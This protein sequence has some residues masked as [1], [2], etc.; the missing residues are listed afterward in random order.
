MNS[1][2]RRWLALAL[3][4]ARLAGRPR[5]E[6]EE[7]VRRSYDRIAAGYDA[8]WTHHMRDLS[9][10][11]LDRL[12]EVG[13]AAAVDLCCGTG[14]VTGALAARTGRP[15][16]GVDASPGMLA[17]ARAAHPGCAFVEADAAAWLRA[18]PPASADVIVTA[19][20]LGYARPW[21]LLRAARRVLRPGGRLAV[22]DNGL[23]SL[24]GVVRASVLAF[25]ERPDALAHVL[26]VG[27]LPSSRAL[28]ALL[29]AAGLRP[30]ARWDGARSYRVASGEEAIARLQ[31]TGAA[32]G[33][34]LACAPGDAADVFARFARILARGAGPEGITLTHRYLGAVAVRP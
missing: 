12:G 30:R 29:R 33:F 17:V 22:L 10:A 32:A 5:R 14:F 11:L 31:A 4:V 23:G 8:A 7:R 13:G 21:A 34:E 6:T 26:R 24:S 27:F 20:A 2:R 19:W 3:R 9:L 15:V 25:A 28:A 18:Q 16:T 1:P